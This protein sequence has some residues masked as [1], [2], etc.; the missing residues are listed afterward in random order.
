MTDATRTAAEATLG[1]TFA[2][3]TLLREALTHTS[4]A[5]TRLCSNERMEFLGDAVLDLVVVDALY[6]AF[7]DY[8]EGD[9]TKV[10]SAVVSRRTCA[11][12]AR[13]LGLDELLIV[14]KGIEGRQHLPASLAANVYESVVAALYL[15]GGY[16]VAKRFVTRT[17]E[18]HIK[19]LSDNEHQHN[20]KAL[21]QQNVQRLYGSSPH[22]ELLDE[23]GPDHSKAFEVCVTLEGRRYAGAWATTKKLAEQ[24]AAL[25]ALLDLEVID[26]AEL[27]EAIL[28]LDAMGP[29][30]L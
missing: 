6:R 10:K 22:Y 26:A 25:N 17:M 18:P 15:D 28:V 21:L 7:P 3:A 29:T 2:D 27:E 9:L 1:H 24:K 30:P 5:D 14:G 12:I 16:D 8:F 13:E 20:Y 4:A 11:A 19:A 23:K